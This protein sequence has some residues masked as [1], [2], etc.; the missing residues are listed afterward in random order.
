MSAQFWMIPVLFTVVAL[1][2]VAAVLVARSWPRTP[3]L[4][5]EER[6]E[7]ADAPMPTL[8]KGAWVGLTL[9]LVTL[10]AAATLITVRGGAMV[11]WVDDDLRLMVLGIFILGLAGTAAATNLPIARAEVGGRLDERD[12]AIVARAPTAQ[13]TL[14][15]LGLAAWL[16]VLGQRFHDEAAVPMVYLYLMFGCVILLVMIGQSLGILLGYFAGGRHG[17]T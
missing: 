6:A 10:A 11:Y 3:D 4:T 7:L 15:I 12:R 14:A 5:A 13:V 1:A 16:V 9:G 17:E 2:A 8:Q